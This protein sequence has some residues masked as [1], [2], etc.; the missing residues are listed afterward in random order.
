[1]SFTFTLDT[2]VR[3]LI[4]IQIVHLMDSNPFYQLMT[5]GIDFHL[6]GLVKITIF[7]LILFSLISSWP[8]INNIVNMVIKILQR[9]RNIYLE[10]TVPQILSVGPS[11]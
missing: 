6:F 4:R 9:Y 1:M 8:R 7:Q 5:L 11:F 10:G 2:S 3:D